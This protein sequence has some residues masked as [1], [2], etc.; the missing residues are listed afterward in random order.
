MLKSIFDYDKIVYTPDEVR[1]N[2]PELRTKLEQM[3]SQTL[4]AQ[5]KH[6]SN[7]PSFEYF[8]RTVFDE[9]GAIAVKKN[10]FKVY[11]TTLSAYYEKQWKHYNVRRLENSQYF[12]L[13]GSMYYMAYI[14]MD[15]SL[16]LVKLFEEIA[17][18]ED[19]L[20][21]VRGV[22]F[23]GNYVDFSLML[24]LLDNRKNHVLE[25]LSALNQLQR[26]IGDFIIEP[27][28][29]D[30]LLAYV[31]S[32]VDDFF[33]LLLTKEFDFENPMLIS[34]FHAEADQLLLNAVKNKHIINKYKEKI[35]RKYREANNPYNNSVLAKAV[36]DEFKREP[37]VDVLFGIEYGGIE[38]PFIVNA[39]FRL[40]GLDQL[41]IYLGK[42]SHYSQV[43][44]GDS[45]MPV[46]PFQDLNAL[47][48]K[49]VLI[50][51]DN[52]LTG[53]TIQKITENL[54][55]LGAKDAYLGLVSCADTKRYYQMIMPDHGL[56][57]PDILLDC[58]LVAAKG[59]YTRIYSSKSYK[60][61]NGVF[62]KIED[63][64]LRYLSG[65][66]PDM[67]FKG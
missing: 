53:Q 34:H 40:G 50:L 18:I 38:L 67:R 13:R 63:K 10:D 44:L 14:D 6:L 1:R 25:I 37:F 48:N 49:R 31:Q 9:T 12:F 17:D 58:A 23:T 15:A 65:N 20:L 7:D 19:V 55:E 5:G 22:Q 8:L 36:Y 54:R 51:E 26:I 27:Q 3:S 33:G 32:A 59:P 62:N 56:I 24:G 2:W 47:S 16:L 30:R 64:I 28:T 41:P 43:K 66:Y 21:R 57:N 52:T 45:V 61:K 35:F 39:F 4:V 60:N 11:N 42:Y 29:Y 46:A